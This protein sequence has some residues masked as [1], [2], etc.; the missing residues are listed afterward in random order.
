MKTNKFFQLLT[1]A[2][3]AVAFAFVTGCEGPEGPVGPQGTKGDT[4]DTGAQGEKGDD[5]T[6][7][8]AGNVTCLECH[9]ADTPQEK[10][11]E[12]QRSVHAAGAIAVD[13]AGGRT[14]CAQC[15]S[16]EGYLEFARTGTV[17]ETILV[18]SAW[19]CKTCHNIHTTFEQ[20]DY[21]FRLGG[22]VTLLA[23]GT[24]V[25]AGG[26]NN[27]CINCHQSRRAV[28][29]YDGATED[30]TFTRKFTGDDIAVY[31][32]AAVG[33]AGSITLIPG[34]A[35]A[36][37]TLVVVFDVPVATH[38]YISSTHAGPHH[39]PQGNVWAGL[40]AVND[41]TAYGAHSDGCVKCHMGPDSGHSF[42]PKE[43]NC[44]VTDCHGGSKQ[45]ALDAFAVRIHAAGEALEAIHA[46]HFDDEDG[47][48]H[49]VYASLP[50]ADFNAWW[51]F[52]VLLEDRS[53]SAHNPAYAETTLA[54]VEA[55]LN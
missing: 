43:A 51:D 8:V 37:D 45:P 46:V 54:G 49:P 21:A 32:T 30:K 15:H 31:T 4:G 3:C 22:D 26:N 16:H 23:D 28:T 55:Q 39:G 42:K 5:G 25:V 27:T 12:F 50:R 19:E 29:Y 53:N 40:G 7:G 17:A 18:P 14:S 41:G 9:S 35:P 36:V 33:P 48:F 44:T 47:T 52:M 34:V 6:P 38:A 13:Y 24:T 20:T 10:L 11:E 1:L 2:I